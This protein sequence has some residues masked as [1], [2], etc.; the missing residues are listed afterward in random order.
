MHESIAKETGVGR[1]KKKNFESGDLSS[2]TESKD[3]RRVRESTGR[4]DLDVEEDR[5]DPETPS[6]MSPTPT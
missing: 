3:W 6:A 1:T 4:P 2:D 5:D